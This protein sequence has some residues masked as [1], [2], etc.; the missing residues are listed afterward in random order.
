LARAFIGVGSNVRPGENFRKAIKLLGL[1]LRIVAISTVYLTEPEGRPEQP[2]FYNGVVEVE[3]ELPPRELKLSVLREIELRLGRARHEDKCAPRTIDLDLL[4]YDDVVESTDD[5]TLPDPQIETRPFLAVP[6]HE[7]APK[8]KLPGAG[9]SIAEIAAAFSSHNMR[10][11]D[12]YTK[13]LRRELRYG[14]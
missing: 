12:D 7:L 5:L 1:R 11:L 3:T 10:P 9:R 13:A 2:P 8:M 4:L 14:P 6:L